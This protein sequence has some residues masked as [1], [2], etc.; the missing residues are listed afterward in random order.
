MKKIKIMIKII[1]TTV[2]ILL[3]STIVFSGNKNVGTTSAMFKVLL[4]PKVVSL[5][6]AYSTFTDADSLVIN[7]A[8]ISLTETKEVSVSY[9]KWLVDT[10]YGYLSFCLPTEVGSFGVSINYFTAG[11]MEEY[12]ADGNPTNK[13]FTANGILTSLVYSR[14]IT[15][16]I[17]LGIAGKFYY[18][19]IEKEYAYSP[20]ADVGSIVVLNEKLKLAAAVQNLFGSIKFINQEDKLPLLLKVGGSYQIIDNFVTAIDINLPADNNVSANIGIEYNLSFSD[21]VI[22]IRAGY[23]SSTDA[24]IGVSLG[25]G[26]RY[27]ETVG[28]NLAWA[29]SISELD[30]QVLNVGV[31]F[32]F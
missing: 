30:Q 6:G 32:K 20:S 1:K 15:E 16:K 13:T 4:S 18:E 8:G 14:K 23:N 11:D 29:P 21:F 12:G 2:C 19:T 28:I 31:A 26:F 24:F 27:K 22:P 25:I 17:S 7:P 10:S 9:T 3:V 5:G